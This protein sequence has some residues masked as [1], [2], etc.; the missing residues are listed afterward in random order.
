M[1]NFVFSIG[2]IAPIGL[3]TA[4]DPLTLQKD[5]GDPGSVDVDFFITPDVAELYKD[6]TDIAP[7]KKM[8]KEVDQFHGKN[9]GNGTLMERAFR[10]DVNRWMQ[11]KNNDGEWVVPIWEDRT[12]VEHILTPSESWERIAWINTELKTCLKFTQIERKERKRYRSRLRL[13]GNQKIPCF[14]Y[15]GL[16]VAGDQD[17]GWVEKCSSTGHIGSFL[18]TALGFVYE[19]MRPDRDQKRI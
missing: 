9:D 19:H 16:E 2:I 10:S 14:S 18:M 6:K 11:S 5:L 17:I 15:I 13:I 7:H 3:A 1:C 12:F 4:I 8:V